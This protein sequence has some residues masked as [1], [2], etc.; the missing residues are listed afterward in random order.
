MDS[1]SIQKLFALA[2]VSAALGKFTLLKRSYAR[3][4]EL[5]CLHRAGKAI[6]GRHETRAGD[7]RDAT[8]FSFALASPGINDR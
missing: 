3:T 8:V 5:E 4:V 7:L 2:I 6:G 1:G